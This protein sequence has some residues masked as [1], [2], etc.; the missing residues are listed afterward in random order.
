MYFWYILLHICIHPNSVGEEGEHDLTNILK[1]MTGLERIPPLGLES[2][3]RLRYKTDDSK[4]LN[5]ETCTLKLLLPTVHN[6]QEDF[7]EYFTIA[8]RQA[9]TGFGLV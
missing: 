2:P 1:F 8:C 6:T 4:T 7:N 9:H 3:I 5:A